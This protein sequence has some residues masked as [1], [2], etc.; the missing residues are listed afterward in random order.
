[1]H[2]K[3]AFFGE[4]FQTE[5]YNEHLDIYLEKP[6]VTIKGNGTGKKNTQRKLKPKNY[7]NTNNTEILMDFLSTYCD[8]NGLGRD[9]QGKLRT[10]LE[11]LK[12]PSVSEQFKQQLKLAISDNS[13]SANTLENETG[14]EFD[15]EEEKIAWFSELWTH[16]YGTDR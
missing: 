8:V 16:L 15:S 1:M 4:K 2:G 5:T 6:Q 11:N 3:N 7:M 10:T 12:D 13:V 9:W 14:W